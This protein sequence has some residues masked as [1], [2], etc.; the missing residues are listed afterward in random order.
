MPVLRSREIPS[1]QPLQSKSPSSSSSPKTLEPKPRLTPP[2]I[3]PITPAKAVESVSL[4]PSPP[5]RR[6]SLRLSGGDVRGPTQ[7]RTRTD[8]SETQELGDSVGGS[9]RVSDD[10]LDRI[11][12]LGQIEGNKQEIG[13]F[14]VLSLRSGTRVAKRVS[15]GDDVRVSDVDLDNLIGNV[16]NDV[17]QLGGNKVL[18]PGLGGRV[19]KKVLI[20]GSDDDD[21]DDWISLDEIVNMVDVKEDEDAVLKHNGS[22]KTTMNLRRYSE[23][24]KGKSKLSI[25]D[26]MV[27]DVLEE[28][29]LSSFRVN[30]N[31][32]LCS[33]KQFN[34]VMVGCANFGIDGQGVV[35]NM[36]EDDSRLFHDDR[37]NLRSPRRYTR[38]EKGKAVLTSD[39]ALLDVHVGDNDDDDVLEKANTELDLNSPAVDVNFDVEVNHEIELDGKMKEREIN[40]RKE[41]RESRLKY[42]REQQKRIAKEN[43][44]KFAHFRM[45]DDEGQGRREEDNEDLED[46]VEAPSEDPLVNVEDWPG[47][48]STA[49]KI[50][51]DREKNLGKQAQNSCSDKGS[52]PVISWTPK[53][54]TG[55]ELKTRTVPSLLSMSFKILAENA[56]AI[57]SLK[58]V[59]D[60]LRHKLCQI[61]C[62]SRRMN[63]QF[64]SLLLEGSPSEIRVSDCSW[65]EEEQFESSIKDCDTST[66]MVLQLD[67]CGHCVSDASLLKAIGPKGFPV[68]TTISLKGACR[69][70]DAG[71]TAIVSAAPVL[72]SMN[73]SQCSLLTDVGIK[74]I[75][76]KL[77]SIV[78]ELYLDDCDTLDAMSILPSLKRLLRLEVL[79]L[80]GIGGVSD[81]FLKQLLTSNGHNMKELVLANCVN[82]TN[83]S[84]KV[85]AEKCPQLCVLDLC[86]LRKLTDVGMAHL[87]NGCSG[88]QDLRL[89]RNAFSDDA[90]AAFLEAS[91]ESLKELSL[92]NITKVGQNTTISLAQRCKN[93][94]MLDLSWCRSLTDDA[95]GLI[96]DSCMSLK[97]LKIFGCT[98]ITRTFIDGHSNPHLHVVGMKLTPILEHIK[99]PNFEH[100]PLY[101]SAVPPS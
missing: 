67:L 17:Q 47:P 73:L 86:Y 20:D 58:F 10:S 81:K 84:L 30:E 91:G 31:D 36:A 16:A 21:D 44:L 101:Y 8:V 19:A 51:R 63:A 35:H 25:D 97:L 87:A 96:A 70:S 13:K 98:Q 54:E 94:E 64:F 29:D 5:Y 14:G 41:I 33:F 34:S 9:V 79:S 4:S 62:D 59:P 100:G 45:E 82:V 90:I 83:S 72:R 26:Q 89:C 68:L 80:R 57:P 76:D 93:L 48:F 52:M 66:L 69:I 92:N 49:M 12:E 18:S 55:L 60:A 53:K 74:T 28:A 38:E 50:I 27:D 23:E 2:L 71:L 77:G 32:D 43:A 24:E 99:R 40:I 95:L 85:I 61:L 37:S 42:M 88:I 6:R 75:A 56:D 7:K 15:F 22:K 39:D 65:L 78:H 11:K 3:E 1:P 46:E